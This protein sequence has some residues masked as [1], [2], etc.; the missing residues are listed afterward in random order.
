MTKLMLGHARRLIEGPE[1]PRGVWPRAAALLSRQALEEAMDQ[2]WA[3]TFP[4]MESASRAT[5]LACLDQVLTDR[6]LVADIRTAWS[7]LSRAC[8]HHY[9]LAPTAAELERCIRQTERLVEALRQT[10]G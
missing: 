9:E 1:G 8:H 7:S 3:C 5:Q 10:G 6:T 4:G 2:L